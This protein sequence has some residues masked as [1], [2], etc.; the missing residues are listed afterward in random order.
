MVQTALNLEKTKLKCLKMLIAVK[1]L[2]LQLFNLVNLSSA[3]RH[4][5]L[6]LN[7]QNLL[8]SVSLLHILTLYLAISSIQA[9]LNLCQILMFSQ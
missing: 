9:N 4:L 6:H 1:Q 2:M 3:Y 5:N 7:W 8:Y